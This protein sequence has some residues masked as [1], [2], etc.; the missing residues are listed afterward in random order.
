MNL[1][2]KIL[3]KDEKRI[4]LEPACFWSPAS[5]WVS[6]GERVKRGEEKKTG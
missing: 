5:P 3:G 4:E 1:L 6:S 2:E